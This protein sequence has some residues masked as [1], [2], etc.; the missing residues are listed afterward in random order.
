M[1]LLDE[2][3]VFMAQRAPADVLRNEL[4]SIFL[5]ELEYF[6]GILFLTT[7][8]LETIDRAFRSRVNVHLLF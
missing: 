8:L 2:A 7:N 3:D 4:V 1:V 5:R 6:Q